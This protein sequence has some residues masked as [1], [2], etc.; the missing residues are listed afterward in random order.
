[1]VAFVVL[2]TTVAGVAV[3]FGFGLLWICGYIVPVVGAL[4]KDGSIHPKDLYIIAIQRM[5]IS[6]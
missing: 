3:P 1:M 2:G 5:V 4:E 6:P